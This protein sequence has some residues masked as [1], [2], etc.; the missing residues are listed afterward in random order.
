MDHDSL[1]LI[2]IWQ[3]L[4]QAQ[5]AEFVRSLPAGLDTPLGEG[6][7]KLSGGQRQRVALARLF[8]KDHDIIILDEATQGL[9]SL[10]AAELLQEIQSWSL[11]KTVITITPVS[12][13]HLDVYKRQ[14]LYRV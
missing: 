11:N 12:Y 14:A 10:T 7:M 3:A 4:A 8:L 6:G 1:S 13:T 5:L 9:D 2:H